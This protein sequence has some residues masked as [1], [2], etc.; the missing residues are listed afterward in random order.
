MNE[1]CKYCGSCID[2]VRFLSLT[3]SEWRCSNCLKQPE[4][5]RG[6]SDKRGT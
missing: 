6:T 5:Y 1:A 3:K 4:D 2:V